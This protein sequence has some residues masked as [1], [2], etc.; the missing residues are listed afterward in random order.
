[1]LRGQLSRAVATPADNNAPIRSRLQVFESA[2][3]DALASHQ[4]VILL[5]P[6]VGSAV[7]GSQVL[8]CHAGS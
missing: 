4:E 8:S 5:Q 3:E 2:G 1:M 6:V 7:V